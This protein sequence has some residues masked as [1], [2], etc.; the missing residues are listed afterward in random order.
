MINDD[1]IKY[2]EAQKMR[3]TLRDSIYQKLIDAGWKVEDV[4]EGL[5]KVFAPVVSAPVYTIPTSKPAEDLIPNLMPKVSGPAG[6]VPI[7]N[8]FELSPNLGQGSSNPVSSFDSFRPIE[9]SEP[10]PTVNVMSPGPLPQG[11]VISSYRKDYQNV[12]SID[13]GAHKSHVGRLIA[14]ILFV[15]LLVSSGVIFANVKGFISLPFDVPFFRPSPEQAMVKMMKNFSSIKTLHYVSDMDISLTM[16]DIQPMM[17]AENPTPTILPAPGSNNNL[18]KIETPAPSAVVNNTVKLHADTDA[19]YS[20]PSSVNLATVANASIS[21]FGGLS[22]NFETEARVI[23]KTYYLKIPNFEMAR[24]F[25]GE[26]NSWISFKQSDFDELS[27]LAEQESIPVSSQTIDEAKMKQISDL[28]K[29]TKFIENITEVGTEKLGDQSTRHY[30]FTVN[31]EVVKNFVSKSLDIINDTNLNANRTVI[32]DNLNY[33]NDIKGD[34]WVAKGTYMPIKFTVA[35]STDEITVMDT[36]KVK[37][38]INISYLLSKINEPVTISEPSGANSILDKV[39]ASMESANIKG[40]DAG[41]KATLASL[42]AENELY[43]DAHKATYGKASMTGNCVAPVKDSIFYNSTVVKS[44]LEKTKNVGSCYS[45]P[46]AWAV[47]VP[48]VSDTTVMWCAD[49]S[50]AMKETKTPLTGLVCK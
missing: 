4:N 48:L 29:S 12:S 41:I 35:L 14:I 37:A 10:T 50:G 28:A 13:T 19:D 24:E 31:K 23:D 36:T 21:L 5:N 43:F 8:S 40:Q 44:L 22:I 30:Q 1:L 27:K 9:K 20:N 6:A 25:V 34:V 39:K 7:K 38:K 47:S 2:I 16:Q 15:L 46:K 18:E 3:G 33:L 11:A 17:S 42:R 32:V 49:S 45:T 26:P